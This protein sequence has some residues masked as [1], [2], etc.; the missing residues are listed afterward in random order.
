MLAWYEAIKK[1]TEVSGAER[2]AFVVQSASRH[3]RTASD[4]SRRTESVS[5][6]NGT[7][8]DDDADEIPYS[9]QHSATEDY[10]DEPLEPLRGA[11]VGRFPSHIS[12]NR[13]FEH[14]HSDGSVIAAAFALPGALYADGG[15][16]EGDACTR[17][18]VPLA[19]QRR[20]DGSLPWSEGKVWSPSRLLLA[21]PPHWLT[22]L[23]S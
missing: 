13:D 15:G 21:P 16:R 8:N 11:N 14:R 9:G 5:S 18:V 3:H 7:D 10:G 2:T 22:I 6:E 19:D 4:G 1:L 17:V 23:A 12:V 20:T